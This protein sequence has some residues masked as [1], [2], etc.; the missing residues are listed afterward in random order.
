MHETPKK[1]SKMQINAAAV[2]AWILEFIRFAKL[3]TNPLK[4][5]RQTVIGLT[6]R[7]GK[8][9]NWWVHKVCAN[10]YYPNSNDSEKKVGFLGSK[11]FLLQEVYAETRKNRMGCNKQL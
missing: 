6:V 1:A 4:T 2:H 7:I 8:G 5:L 10:I 11:T 3:G 9:C